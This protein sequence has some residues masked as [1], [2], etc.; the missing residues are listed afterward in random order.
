MWY[1]AGRWTGG[2]SGLS[3]MVAVPADIRADAER[4]LRRRRDARAVVLFGSRARGQAHEFSDWDVAL[5]T[6]S[7]DRERFLEPDEHG[8]SRSNVDCLVMPESV[9]EADSRTVGRLTRGLLRDAVV[10]AGRWTRNLPATGVHMNVDDYISH[11]KAALK[12]FK[13]SADEYGELGDE[14]ASWRSD[15]SACDA[16]VQLTSDAT[17]RSGKA[18]LIGLGLDPEHSHSMAKLAE[19]A[20]RAGFSDQARRL[21]DLNGGTHQDHMADYIGEAK[22]TVEQCR[23]AIPRF[24]GALRL[25]GHLMAH[26]PDE[27]SDDDRREAMLRSVA[28]L[29]KMTERISEA[30]IGGYCASGGPQPKV[31]VLLDAQAALT[32][33]VKEVAASIEF[34]VRE[35]E[36]AN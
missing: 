10:L 3:D 19:Q 2:I 23:R 31:A 11:L 1:S 17:E 24:Q 16:F 33:A 29:G 25:Y 13:R 14:L 9:I 27:V 30:E 18:L 4:L 36:M 35:H 34:S 6:R 20:R 8:F 28:V 12:R 32:E 22:A 7:G 26:W 21:A 15:D 5:I